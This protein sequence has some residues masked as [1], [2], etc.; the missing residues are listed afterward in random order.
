MNKKIIILSLAAIFS[1]IIVTAVRAD[2]ATSTDPGSTD[3]LTQLQQKQQQIAAINAQLGTAKADLKNVQTQKVTLQQQITLVN[4]SIT[5]LNLGITADQLTTQKLQLQIQQLNSDQTDIT[6]SIAT[7]QQA[8]GSLLA[9]VQKNDVANGNLLVVFLKQKSLA[10]GVL[11][12]QSLHTLQDQLS[13]DIGNLKD[14]HNQYNNQI[15]L[16]S[17]KATAIAGEQQDL[18]SKQSILQ[19]QEQQKQTLLASTKSQESAFQK[20]LTTLQQQQTTINN[21][22]EAIDAVLRTKI[23]PSTLPAINSGVLLMPVQ[24]DNQSDITQGYGATAF[25]KMEY[26]HHWHN[27][28]DFGAPIGTAIL[29]AADG[30]VAAQGNE[31]LYCPHGAYGKFIVINHSNGL[32][33][34]YGHLSKILV[35]AGQTVTRGQLIAYSGNTGDVTGPH[36]HFTVFAQSTYSL[37]SSK[38]CG[39]LPQGGDLDPTGYL[40]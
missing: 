17:A 28:L 25:A 12:A 14:L 16:S 26:V 38:S 32:T 34:L 20:Q 2:T 10:D 36:L 9:E 18:V 6:A 30:T 27:G 35:T 21:E 24:G 37:A 8:I 15:Q 19:D 4:G 40:F 23:N 29:A 11:E 3:L 5:T 22:I 7:K 31:D 13:S 1:L 33:T 39:P